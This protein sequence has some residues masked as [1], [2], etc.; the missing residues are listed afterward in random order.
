MFESA[1]AISSEAVSAVKNDEKTR[2]F[3]RFLTKSQSRAYA[4]IRGLV[5]SRSDAD[6]VLQETLMIA[7]EK[8]DQFDPDTDFTRWVCSIARLEVLTLKRNQQR[9]MPFFTERLAEALANDLGELANDLD[10]RTEALEHCRGELRPR[11]Q[12]LLRRRYANQQSVSE[13]AGEL[14]RTESAVYKALQ[15]IHDALFDCIERQLAME[16]QK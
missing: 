12:D 11:Q 1:P 8:F 14:E 2:Q 6:D 13:I 9:L 4:F 3:V 10:A 15:K 7:W 16:R 5:R